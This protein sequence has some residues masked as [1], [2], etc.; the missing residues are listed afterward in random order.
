MLTQL[1]AFLHWYTCVWVGIRQK[2]YIFL[3]YNDWCT[4]SYIGVVFFHSFTNHKLGRIP[5]GSLPKCLLARGKGIEMPKPEGLGIL[6]LPIPRVNN[7]LYK[8][9]DFIH[10]IIWRLCSKFWKRRQSWLYRTISK[11][12]LVGVIARHFAS[13]M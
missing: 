10:F 4:C 8:S 11:W 2:H 9:E 3:H 7:Q 5:E 1:N 12:Y 13:T 6:L